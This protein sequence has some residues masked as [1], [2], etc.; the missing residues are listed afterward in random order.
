M[1]IY[2]KFGTDRVLETEGAWCWLIPEVPPDPGVGIKL[3]SEHSPKVSSV[4][5]RHLKKYRNFF[6]GFDMPHQVRDEIDIEV[7]CAGVVDWKGF[8][9]PDGQPLA[10]TGE[11]VRQ[12]MTDLR[13]IRDA[14]LMQMKTSEN[15]RA[16]EVAA[17]GKT[18]P[19]PSG[20]VSA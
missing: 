20:R 5:Q 10:C 3:L 17:M 7:A 15:F 2:Q 13:E 12:V 19:T 6:M 8:T 18:S 9:G 1:N 11:H 4:M 14:V 16:A